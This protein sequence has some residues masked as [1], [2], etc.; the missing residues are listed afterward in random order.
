MRN[1]PFVHLSLGLILELC[2]TFP[3]GLLSSAA[4]SLDPDQD[5]QNIGPDMDIKCLTLMVFVP[6]KIF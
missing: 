6:K 5:Q 1:A 4:N 2:R 3:N